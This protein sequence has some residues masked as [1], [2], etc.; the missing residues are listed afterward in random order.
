MAAERSE[1]MAGGNPFF[2]WLKNVLFP[3][4]LQPRE[5]KASPAEV[6]EAADIARGGQKNLTRALAG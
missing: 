6:G 1:A 5:E 4:G 3:M 2:S